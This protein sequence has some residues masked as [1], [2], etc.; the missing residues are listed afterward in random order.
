MRQW[1]STTCTMN[2]VASL[3]LAFPSFAGVLAAGMFMGHNGSTIQEF[4]ELN[5][6]NVEYR[7]SSVRP[8][9]AIQVGAVLFRGTKFQRGKRE[10]LAYTLKGTAFM[11]KR[12]CPPAGYAVIGEQ[13]NSR[14][15]L[16]G[17]APVH[18]KGS[19]DVTGYD[20]WNKN[21]A[22]LFDIAE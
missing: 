8:G 18:A 6:N 15:V 21:A 9:L 10:G 22:L 1:S 7:Y 3:V 2:L 12:G 19:C 5:S 16:K 13:T 14:V 20:Q 11:F 17:A 4:T